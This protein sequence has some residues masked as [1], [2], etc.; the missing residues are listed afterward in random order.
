MLDKLTDKDQEQEV[1]TQNSKEPEITEFEKTQIISAALKDSGSD[2]MLKKAALELVEK[3]PQQQIAKSVSVQTR[4]ADFLNS[5]SSAS[6]L[7]HLVARAIGLGKLISY[8][9]GKSRLVFDGDEWEITLRKTKTTFILDTPAGTI[10]LSQLKS[11]DVEIEEKLEGVMN[12]I[13]K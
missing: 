7:I 13:I 6:R 2:Q 9:K 12:L 10:D 5:R 3:Q 4:I 8:L 1:S 11:G